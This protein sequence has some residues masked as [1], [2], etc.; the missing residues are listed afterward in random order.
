MTTHRGSPVHRRNKSGLSGWKRIINIKSNERLPDYYV[1][2][3]S[4][5]DANDGKS[6]ATAW[7]TIAKV[8]ATY[9]APGKFVGFKRGGIWREQ[10]A[11]NQSGL[12][13]NPIVYGAY[14]IGAPPI[15]TGSNLYITPTY[16]WVLSGSGINQYYLQTAA[17]GNPGIASD[18]N[19]IFINK[20]WATKGSFA[21]MFNGQYMYGD[22]DGLGYNTIYIR[23][24]LGDPDIVGTV[25]EIPRRSY[26][27]FWGAPVDYVTFQDL[28]LQ[29]A[30]G[31]GFY[32]GAA[33][34]N[35]IFQR[36]TAVNNCMRGFAFQDGG[37]SS[38]LLYN[39]KVTCDLA[40]PTNYIINYDV[41][42]GTLTITDSLLKNHFWGLYVQHGTANIE[43]TI[44]TGMIDQ[45][46]ATLIGGGATVNV[47]DS[48]LGST[49]NTGGS[50]NVDNLG[51]GIVTIRNS[52]CLSSFTNPNFMSW[53]N[54]TDGGGNTFG[55]ILFN[56]PAYPPLVGFDVD[57]AEGFWANLTDIINGANVRGFPV[58]ALV[59]T[60]NYGLP[61]NWVNMQSVING[62]NFVDAHS[63]THP[64]F[65]MPQVAFTLRYN[66]AC[67]TATVTIDVVAHSLKTTID[68][69]DD[70]T[71]DL[72]NPL[73]QYV[74]LIVNKINT[75]P[76]YVAVLNGY[77]Q[78]ADYVDLADVAGSSIK[79]VTLNISLDEARTFT[80]EINGSKADLEAHLVN[81]DLS[82]YIAKYLGYPWGNWNTA[83]LA[84]TKAAGFVASRE[85]QSKTENNFTKFDLMLI[86]CVDI[87][88]Q[89][90]T[91][92]ANLVRSIMTALDYAT[93]HGCAINITCHPTGIATFAQKMRILDIVNTYSG[94]IY[95]MSA[96][97]QIK[98]IT[99]VL[100]GILPVGTDVDGTGRY[101]QHEMVDNADYGNIYGAV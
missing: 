96:Y 15:I 1:D 11:Q 36:L 7:Q 31:H 2:N 81:A 72:A 37:P 44:F 66:G 97:D 70:I 75:Y 10:F 80:N 92:D 9:L 90:F 88:A 3:L 16:R 5:S 68:G 19:A 101:W 52:K 38:V 51:G 13:G 21:F 74:P 100:T 67:A 17:G 30:V 22:N 34:S 59:D 87:D 48:K 64:R 60:E 27:I 65:D 32:S 83:V 57:N 35:I 94:A 18:P 62:G 29:H 45:N 49:C 8:Q 43:R 76:N 63:R 40:S 24:D 71:L 28:Q 23:N 85:G 55:D 98:H 54:V 89:D 4:G 25:I 82:P 78:M 56:K 12:A 73:Y 58:T 50:Y 69:V 93:S 86:K 79:A 77:A 20:K 39:I 41:P 14:G 91:S 61:M 46:I 53:R 99:N 33:S 95:R 47:N 6:P 84:A 26:C 42:G